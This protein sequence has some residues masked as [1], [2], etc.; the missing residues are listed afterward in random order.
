MLI[1]Q[2]T[3]LHVRP[4]GRPAYRVAETNMLVARAVGALLAL[5]PRPDAVLVSGDLTDCGLAEEYEELRA[6]LARLPMPVYVVPGNHDRRETLRDVLPAAYRPGARA[7]FVQYAVKDHPVRLIGLDTLVPGHGHG[8]LCGDRL[9]FLEEALAAGDGRPT[10]VFLHHPPFVCGIAHMDAIRLIEGEARFR[11]LIAAHGDVERVLCGHHHRPIQA[12]YAGT[13]AQIAPS[14][15]HQVALDL[16]P[17]HAGALVLE[18][19]AYLLH[20]WEPGAG[21]VSHMAYV[22]SFP[23]PYP[24]VLD[25]DYPGQGR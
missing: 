8:A 2:I 16:T 4:R 10:L 7:G 11:A 19:P 14:V 21:L 18:P 17:E 13:I 15:A 24:F 1:A 5:E 23:G 20:R 25:A 22:E 12:R 6:L 3:D 9:A